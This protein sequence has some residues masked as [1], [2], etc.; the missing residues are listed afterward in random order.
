MGTVNISTNLSKRF[1]PQRKLLRGW[2]ANPWLAVVITGLAYT[3]RAWKYIARP[4]LYAEDGFIW[5]ADGYNKGLSSLVTPLNG[6]FHLPERIFGLVMAQLP[7]QFAPF[8]FNIAA[9]VLFCV[10]VWYLFSNRTKILEGTYQRLFVMLALCLIANVEEF[11]FNFSNSIFLLGIIGVLLVIAKPSQRKGVRIA[12]AVLFALSCFTL[13][14]AF[15]Y[16]PILVFERW[17]FKAKNNVYLVIAGLGS[18]VQLITYLTAHAE[19]SVV[20]F[21]ALLTSQYTVLEIYNQI[22]MPALRFGRLDYALRSGRSGAIMAGLV[23]GLCILLSLLALRS[24][25]KQTR[26]LLFFFALMTAA[27]LKSPIVI[28]ESPVKAIAF[29]AGATGG[30]RYFIF[31]IIGLY[32]MFAKFSFEYLRPSTRYPALAS[33]IIFGLLTS[34]Q[35]RSL[36]I[37]KNFQ[38]FRQAYREGVQ[39]I[40]TKGNTETVV[41]PENPVGFSITLKPKK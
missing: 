28:S 35:T 23:V 15:F 16:L 39:K 11:F 8:L 7:L 25:N 20:T 30:D 21:K 29:M 18:I 12:E 2:I 14:F 22:V 41:M 34:V 31:G 9:L 13:P 19:R 6:F 38:D 32:I 24:A 4:Q 26:Y 17:R 36:V 40:Q 5:L 33:Y 3:A 27:S 1:A 10:T 37:N